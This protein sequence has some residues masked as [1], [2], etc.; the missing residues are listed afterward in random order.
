MKSSSPDPLPPLGQPVPKAPRPE[1]EEWI[2]VPG[3]PHFE[4][5]RQGQYRTAIPPPPP[6]P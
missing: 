4:V 5:N 1:R 2:P 6:K 3:K